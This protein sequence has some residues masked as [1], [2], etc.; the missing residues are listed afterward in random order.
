MTLASVE[1]LFILKILTGTITLD[2]EASL[3]VAACLGRTDTRGIRTTT[4]SW[5]RIFWGSECNGY[6]RS[7]GNEEPHCKI[8][9]E[10]FSELML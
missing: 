4:R 2:P 6:D 8:W 3:L 1:H 9:V 7:G 10:D 5:V